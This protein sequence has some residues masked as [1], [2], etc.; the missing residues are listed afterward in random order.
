[1][2]EPTKTFPV[3]FNPQEAQALLML[4]HLA[5]KSAGLEGSHAANAVHFQTKINKAFEEQKQPKNFEDET[6]VTV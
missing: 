3:E 6:K 1:M 4:L 5:V 2:S